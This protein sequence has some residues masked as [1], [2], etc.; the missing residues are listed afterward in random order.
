MNKKAEEILGLTYDQFCQVVML[1]QGKFE[2]LLV[3]NSEEKEKILTSLFHADRWNQIVLG[4]KAKVDEETKRLEKELADIQGQLSVYACTSV[5]GLKEKLTALEEEVGS[6]KTAVQ[7]AEKLKKKTAKAY[8][9]S[10]KDNELFTALEACRT[11]LETLKQQAEEYDR[12]RNDLK[13]SEAADAIREIHTA[14]TVAKGALDSAA[15]ELGNA[16]T[17]LS[18]AEESDAAAKKKKELHEA[19]R[20]SYNADKETLTGLKDA[21]ELYASIGKKKKASEDAAKEEKKKKKVADAAKKAYETAR[22]QWEKARVASEDAARAFRETSLQY[23][24]NIA[25]T[26]ASK[27]EDGVPC[28]VCGS[29]QHPAPAELAEGV[30]ASEDDVEAANQAMKSTSDTLT[31]AKSAMDAAEDASSRA[32][33]D[34][35]TA[36]GIAVAAKTDYEVSLENIIAG[37]DDSKALESE[38]KTVEDRIKAFESAEKTVADGISAAASALSAAQQRKND[39]LSKESS[40]REKL[41]TEAKKW[42]AALAEKGFSD[43]AAFDAA[44]KEKDFL[45]SERSAIVTFDADLKTAQNAFDEQQKKTEGIEAPEMKALQD[46]KKQAEDAWKEKND[47]L[48]TASQKSKDM[49]KLY[50]SLSKRWERYQVEKTIADSNTDFARKLNSSTGLSLQRYVLGIM[51]T[52]ITVAANQLLKTV[53]SGRYQLYRSYQDFAAH[54]QILD[55]FCLHRSDGNI[56]PY[57]RPVEFLHL[58]VGIE[59]QPIPVF[60]EEAVQ[61]FILQKIGILPTVIAS[62]KGV[63]LPFHEIFPPR[64]HDQ[65]QVFR[66]SAFKLVKT[67]EA[68]DFHHVLRLPQLFSDQP[69]FLFTGHD[70][71]IRR[72]FRPGMPRDRFVGHPVLQKNGLPLRTE[73][74]VLFHVMIKHHVGGKAAV[75]G[76]EQRFRAKHADAVSEGAEFHPF[77]EGAHLR[78]VGRIPG[79]HVDGADLGVLSPEIAI[80]TE[81]VVS[82][83]RAA[84]RDEPGM[85]RELRDRQADTCRAV[86]SQMIQDPA[87]FCELHIFLRTVSCRGRPPASTRRSH[88]SCVFL[89]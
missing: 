55:V 39:A 35:T 24:A 50:E 10:I 44:L 30:S 37:I 59:N 47:T 65:D 63:R 14:F 86:H 87:Y 77:S 36:Q 25:G 40:A 42:A 28:P 88:P 5:D 68:G 9:D 70:E 66:L 43:D 60:P 11:K 57:C 7:E 3:S 74:G 32:T 16:E 82:C 4:V 31:E 85:R 17:A 12:R 19:G 71:Q 27:L 81:A 29:T 53:R 41:K 61:F 56:I 6:L 20:A 21:R 22:D 26:L 38:I 15:E 79:D 78:P 72:T 75:V 51:L 67:G 52:S 8:E 80:E 62:G 73:K 48:T 34:Y 45:V 54:Q 1:P 76:A 2:R 49:K 89:K 83:V 64:G 13:L 46:A 18:T 33:E 84:L 23:T 69:R 58:D